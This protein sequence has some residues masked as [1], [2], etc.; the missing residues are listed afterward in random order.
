MPAKRVRGNPKWHVFG[1]VHPQTKK[2]KVVVPSHVTAPP[3]EL[4]EHL[5]AENNLTAAKGAAASAKLSSGETTPYEFPFIREMLHEAPE[6]SL[7][8]DSMIAYSKKMR[9]V[10]EV[11]TRAYEECF[12]REPHNK[13]ER[14]CAM[15]DNCEGLKIDCIS[16]LKFPLREF[17]TPNEQH[18]VET[19]GKLPK[20]HRLCLLCKRTEIAKAFYNIL[21]D[22][23][24]VKQ[25]AIL[26][27]YRNLV[28]VPGEYCIEDCMVS[29]SQ[30]YQGLLDPIV[31]HRRDLYKIVTVDGV[32]Y[33]KQYKLPSPGE[34]RCLH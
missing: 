8:P 14:V 31:Q 7:P 25:D 16:G 4:F 27:D 21:N 30:R 12:L 26:Q 28:G 17:F 2:K 13:L 3:E 20:E 19:T 32:R 15:G 18:G 1:D 22:G 6:K 29:G 34:R 11:V 23:M 24:A 10:V 5:I 33:L 9:N